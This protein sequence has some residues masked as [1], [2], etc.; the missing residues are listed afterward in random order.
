MNPRVSA[1]ELESI[2]IAFAE[3]DTDHLK[4][5]MELPREYLAEKVLLPM[6]E[7]LSKGV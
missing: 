4:V 6:A 7:D 1:R 5:P 3:G 2:E